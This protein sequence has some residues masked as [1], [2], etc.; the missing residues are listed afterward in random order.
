MLY[1]KSDFDDT[2]D[3]VRE[4]A[5][6]VLDIFNEANMNTVTDP[7][8]GLMMDTNVSKQ[9]GVMAVSRLRQASA[10]AAEFL[11]KNPRQVFHVKIE[12]ED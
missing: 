5:R 6:E 12:N 2:M 10:K 7:K 9:R 4:A 1:T 3:E 11:N 8:Y